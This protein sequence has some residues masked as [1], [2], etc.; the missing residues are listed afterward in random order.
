MLYMP[1]IAFTLIFI[2][3]CDDAGYNTTFAGQKCIIKDKAGT[4]LFQASKYHG[5]Y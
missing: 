1:D 5:L 4:I 3:K 2:G